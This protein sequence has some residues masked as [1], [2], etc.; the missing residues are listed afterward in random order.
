MR[1]N[2]E[3]LLMLAEDAQAE[4]D[5]L[6]VEQNKINLAHGRKLWELFQMIEH[7]RTLLQ[8]EM[9]R[10]QRYLPQEQSHAAQTGIVQGDGQRE[11]PR[12]RASRTSAA[13]TAPD[14]RYCDVGGATVEAVASATSVAPV[15]IRWGP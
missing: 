14:Y 2:V 9:S 6:V 12:A 13:F 8:N 15:G 5:Q 4:G 1:S 11:H 3:V 10:F 7:A